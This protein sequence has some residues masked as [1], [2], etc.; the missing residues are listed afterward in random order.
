MTEAYDNTKNS[1]T[2]QKLKSKLIL[3]AYHCV[4]SIIMTSLPAPY[5]H[6]S[7]S[8]VSTFHI[9]PCWL[10][11]LKEGY[12]SNVGPDCELKVLSYRGNGCFL[13]S[14]ALGC[15]VNFWQ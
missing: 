6:S 12:S 2:G 3:C 13:V 10:Q 15:F 14:S 11:S 7:L 4:S 8:V 5:R 1:S 9:H